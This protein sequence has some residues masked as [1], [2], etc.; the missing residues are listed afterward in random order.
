MSV[1]HMFGVRRGKLTRQQQLLR[2]R[3]AAKYGAWHTYA[4]I[5]G[6]GMQSWF[7]CRNMGSPFNENVAKAVLGELARCEPDA[8]D[9]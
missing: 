5:P 4:S 6:T 7:S 8:S 9:G 3:I 2:E 1:E